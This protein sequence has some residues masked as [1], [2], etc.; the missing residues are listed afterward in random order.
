MSLLHQKL[1]H[2][3]HF[4]DTMGGIIRRI[5]FFPTEP[6]PGVSSEREAEAREVLYRGRCGGGGDY[7][8]LPCVC[9]W[10]VVL[11]VRA[12]ARVDLDRK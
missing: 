2:C 10:V 7:L 4:G 12:R 11:V 8:Q 9:R 3:P 6:F 5:P 1:N